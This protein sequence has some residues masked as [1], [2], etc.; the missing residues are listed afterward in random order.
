MERVKAI[1]AFFEAI[2]WAILKDLL[3]KRKPPIVD[4]HLAGDEGAIVSSQK[5]CGTDQVLR[6]TWSLDTSPWNLELIKG[7]HG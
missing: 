4:N 3:M 6:Y 7:W 1:M 5:K 2:S